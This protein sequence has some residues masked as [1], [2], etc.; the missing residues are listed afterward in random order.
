MGADSGRGEML[1]GGRVGKDSW[2]EGEVFRAADGGS[3]PCSG[4]GGTCQV[5][6]VEGRHEAG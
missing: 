1:P 6:G 4:R 5:A 3:V 2:R